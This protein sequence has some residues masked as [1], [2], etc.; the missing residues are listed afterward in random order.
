MNVI[1]K[2]HVNHVNPVKKS[3]SGYLC[4]SAANC[5]FIGLLLQ[6]H[7]EGLSVML[8]FVTCKSKI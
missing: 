2:D 8:L 3:I 6:K 1:K 4:K 5:F 7:A